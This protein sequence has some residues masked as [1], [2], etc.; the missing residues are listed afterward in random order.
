MNI[1]HITM[2]TFHKIVQDELKWADLNS[3]FYQS[4]KHDLSNN[5][6]NILEYMIKL[7]KLLTKYK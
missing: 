4:D 2:R 5:V 6:L 7:N 1:N 3:E